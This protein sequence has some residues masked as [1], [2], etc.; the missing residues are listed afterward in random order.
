MNYEQ[1]NLV[2]YE[3]ANWFIDFEHLYGNFTVLIKL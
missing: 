1:H 3:D 2:Q